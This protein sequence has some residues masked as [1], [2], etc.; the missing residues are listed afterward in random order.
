MCAVK[1]FHC[2]KWNRLVKYGQVHI[3][4][5]RK[6]NLIYPIKI[7]IYNEKCIFLQSNQAMMNNNNKIFH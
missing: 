5:R 2:C 3:T 4:F 7:E 6:D 1:V